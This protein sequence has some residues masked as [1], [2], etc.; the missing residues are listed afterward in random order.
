MNIFK[1]I[2]LILSV[3]CIAFPAHGMD[4]DDGNQGFF[5]RIWGAAKEH[6]V[7]VGAAVAL[8]GLGVGY[9]AHRRYDLNAHLFSAVGRNAAFETA[10]LLK[11]KA[12]VNAKTEMGDTPLHVAARNGNMGIGKLLLAAGAKINEHRYGAHV[13]PTPLI[14]A[15][16]CNQ[17]KMIELL[18]A[19]GAHY[20]IYN[21]RSVGE[22]F[23][24]VIKR[25]DV[26]KKIILPKLANVEALE[27]IA[28]IYCDSLIN[29]ILTYSEFRN[30]ADQKAS[31]KRI[32][33]ALCILK[34]HSMPK[35]VRLKLLSY[36]PEDVFNSEHAR[37]LLLAEASVKDL[38]AY[39]PLDWF[40]KI[41]QDTDNAYKLA[42]LDTMVLDIVE[43]RLRKMRELLL[44]IKSNHGLQ[45]LDPNNVEQH[46]EAI[47]QNVRAAFV[48]DAHQ[49][50]IN[51]NNNE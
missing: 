39:C 38:A 12:N 28:S 4:Q 23:I 6:P 32:M 14:D 11:L 20:S 34:R 7:I 25:S 35:V 24:H 31:Y 47:E 29:Q 8:V 5:G 33:T 26:I 16:S 30:S 43:Y 51:N 37:L 27:R 2:T 42:F 3:A 46:R 48:G 45:A 13:H 21:Y 49:A 36:M 17:D 19:K 44:Q 50:D 10:L 22:L 1:K 18:L 40:V 41:Y 9:E 15:I